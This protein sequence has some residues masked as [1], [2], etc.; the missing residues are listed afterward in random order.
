TLVHDNKPANG[1]GEL[2]RIPGGNLQADISFD[3]SH[4]FD[5]THL[6][7]NEN[8]SNEDSKNETVL[9]T[10]GNSQSSVLRDSSIVDYECLYP[11]CSVKTKYYDEYITHRATHPK[12]FIYE[13]KEPGCGRIYHCPSSFSTHKEKHKPEIR[14]KKC[15][16]CF[17]NRAKLRLH[18]KNCNTEHLRI[19]LITAENLHFDI[20]NFQ[21]LITANRTIM[22]NFPDEKNHECPYVGCTMKTKSRTE[23]I[24]HRKT[25]PKPFIN[26]CK[27]PGCG[28]TFNYQSVFSRH[29]EKHRPKCQC[30][31]CGNVF[32]YKNNLKAHE[33]CCTATSH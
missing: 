11:A 20:D 31:N 21:I 15:D 10:T 33:K 5:F 16:E 23:Y 27:V 19:D 18:K 25:H 7:R 14:C 17:S 29:Q 1:D 4:F 22:E 6:R 3:S 32:I 12:P 28:Q 30:R 2:P 24:A 9:I 8:R 26:E 13:C